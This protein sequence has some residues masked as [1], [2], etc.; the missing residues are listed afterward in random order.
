MVHVQSDI[1]FL[2]S[3][4]TTKSKIKRLQSCMVFSLTLCSYKTHGELA[5]FSIIYQAQFKSNLPDILCFLCNVNCTNNSHNLCAS[6]PQAC[7]AIFF[8]EFLV[9]LFQ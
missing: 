6:L 7:L 5:H 9:F 2:C 1:E 8:K 4:E 3:E